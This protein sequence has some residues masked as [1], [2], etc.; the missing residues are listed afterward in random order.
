MTAGGPCEEKYWRMIDEVIIDDLTAAKWEV[1]RKHFAVCPACRA[2]YNRAVL[3]ERMLHGGPEA[4]G[5]P[6]TRELDRIAAAVLG[7]EGDAPSRWRRLV[8]W[9]APTQRWAVGLAAAAA[10]LALIPILTSRVPTKAPEPEGTF[11]PRGPGKGPVE[12]FAS[13]PNLKPAERAAGLRA[14]CLAGDRVEALDPK[15]SA[16]PRCARHDQL[17]LAVSNPGKYQRVFLVGL[18]HDHSLKWYAPRP[19]EVAS[20]AAP[21]STDA[22]ADVPVGASIRLAV[23]H[24]PGALR[25]YALFSDTPIKAEEIEAA[26]ADLEKNGV[27]PMDA[28]TLPLS[29]PDVL[30]RSL[31]IDI[32]P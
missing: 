14:F 18:A 13:Q 7:R 29:R 27:R 12:L 9:F 25:I 19:P 4:V 28:P 26:A 22:I 3:A 24:D 6:S 31:L 32:K 23:N 10:C 17:K 20:V 11:L 8:A 16:P 21:L 5:R 30:Q 15:G 1:L 2:R